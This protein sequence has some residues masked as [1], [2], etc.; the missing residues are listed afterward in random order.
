MGRRCS[1]AMLGGKL[2]KAQSKGTWVVKWADS[3]TIV[4]LRVYVEKPCQWCDSVRDQRTGVGRIQ[5]DS[6]LSS[7]EE[8]TYGDQ[9]SWVGMRWGKAKG[10]LLGSRPTGSEDHRGVLGV[11]ERR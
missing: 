8:S 11:L 6:S 4:T 2:W 1:V 10:L 7:F 5:P 3:G 9:D